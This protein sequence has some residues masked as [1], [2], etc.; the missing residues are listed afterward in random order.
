MPCRE[1]A[2]WSE[3]SD[4]CPVAFSSKK[5]VCPKHGS[6]ERPGSLP[7]DAKLLA[8]NCFGEYTTWQYWRRDL[9][10]DELYTMHK[11]GKRL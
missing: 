7:R 1:W 4:I 6:I 3:A 8:A 11:V 10:I 9:Q 5:M 2:Q